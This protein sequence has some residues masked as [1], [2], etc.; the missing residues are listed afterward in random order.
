MKTIHLQTLAT[1][2][3]CV[4]VGGCEANKSRNPLSPSVA[5]PIAG[6]TITAPEAARAPQ[7]PDL[8]RRRGRHAADRERVD[9]R[10]AP[11]LAAGGDRQR[12]RVPEQGPRRR[13]GVAR[14]PADARRTR[15]LSPWRPPA[16]GTTGAPAPWTGPTPA[17][18]RP[19]PASSCRIPSSSAPPL[20]WTDRAATHGGLHHARPDSDQR[21]GHGSVE[22]RH[23]YRFDIAT[24]SNFANMVAV[25]TVPRS[26]GTTTTARPTPLAYNTVYYW[27]VTAT[28]GVIV[29]PLSPVAS[30]RTP[31]APVRPPPRRR[32]P[33]PSP[34]PGAGAVAEPESRAGPGPGWRP[35]A[36]S[37]RRPAPP[38]AE[39]GLG[40]RGSGAPVPRRAAEF[41]P[42]ERRHVGVHGSRRRSAAAVRHALGLQRQAWQQQRSRPTTWSTTTGARTATRA[43]PTSTSST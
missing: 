4:V 15:C 14:G 31:A 26:G 8:D 23:H 6:V 27:R 21:P 40:G 16:R 34:S 17:N 39:H 32:H 2:A 11:D 13:Q 30:F 24:D 43:R 38:A 1:L 18:S 10:R 41:L 33:S 3:L 7:Q 25:L 28:D 20:R 29:S 35:G 19:R 37:G 9:Q 42:V 5:G 22:R 12:Q 36:Q